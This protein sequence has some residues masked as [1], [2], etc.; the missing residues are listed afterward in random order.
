[1]DVVVVGVVVGVVFV[2]FAV[3][4]L[5]VL[6]FVV[7][8]WLAFAFD[9]LTFPWGEEILAEPL[10]FVFGFVCVRH[11]SKRSWLLLSFA[12]S[13]DS[14]FIASSIA[15]DSVSPTTVT[16]TPKSVVVLGPGAGA[17]PCTSRCEPPTDFR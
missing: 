12:I 3:T 15:E 4:V 1:M 13:A 14:S 16:G 10:F 6:L 5:V 8:V 7:D 17:G 11:C 9:A 2:V